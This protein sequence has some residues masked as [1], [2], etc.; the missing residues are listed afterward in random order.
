MANYMRRDIDKE[1]VDNAIRLGQK[2]MVMYYYKF[3]SP[4]MIKNHTN[5]WFSY[6]C[7]YNRAEIAKFI[8][9]KYSSHINLN[10]DNYYIFVKS[11]PK[12]KPEIAELLEDYTVFARTRFIVDWEKVRSNNAEYASI[13]II[14]PSYPVPNFICTRYHHPIEYAI[15][16]YSDKQPDYDFLAMVNR[17]RKSANL[18]QK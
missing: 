9:D 1:C 15:E 5:E 17:P 3:I 7:M 2:S 10:H 16:V 13:Y 11:Y 12:Y 4:E 6:T 14:S 18:K 8:I